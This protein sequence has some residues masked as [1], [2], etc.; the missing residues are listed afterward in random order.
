MTHYCSLLVAGDVDP[1]QKKIQTSNRWEIKA[2][3]LSSL[4]LCHPYD[5]LVRYPLFLKL[6]F[7]LSLIPKTPNR[8]SK[9]KENHE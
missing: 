1:R 9:G 4:K 5:Y 2:I 6:F 3:F 8:A 7:Q